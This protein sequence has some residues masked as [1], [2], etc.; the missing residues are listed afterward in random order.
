MAAA[1]YREL[2]TKKDTVK[3]CAIRPG[4]DGKAESNPDVPLES[5]P[6]LH[7]FSKF[8]FMLHADVLLN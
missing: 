2:V 4:T 6:T 7:D 8:V 3:F 5:R 1:K